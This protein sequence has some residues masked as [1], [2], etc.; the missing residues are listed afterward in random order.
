MK[1]E[2]MKPLLRRP[3]TD[4]VLLHPSFLSQGRMSFTWGSTRY[5]SGSLYLGLRRYVDQQ[6]L[7][8]PDRLESM[9][10]EWRDPKKD[11]P[12]LAQEELV[13]LTLRRGGFAGIVENHL[14]HP[15]DHAEVIELQLVVMPRFHDSRIAG[16]EINLAELLEE[17]VVRPEDFHQPAALV[18]DHLELFDHHAV[19]HRALLKTG[20][21]NLGTF[22]NFKSYCVGDT[23]KKF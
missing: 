19:D 9:I 7:L 3:A 6:R 11:R 1:F 10:D 5:S 17:V 21:N 2:P 4:A 23:L 16:R 22:L 13:H 20:T 8:R 18:R 12:V 15:L 14:H